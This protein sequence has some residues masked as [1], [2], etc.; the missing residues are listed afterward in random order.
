[1]TPAG[2]SFERLV[3]HGAVGGGVFLRA[4]RWS[5]TIRLITFGCGVAAVAAVAAAV[6]GIAV[7][8][9]VGA[10][11]VVALAT[12]ALSAVR[13]YTVSS[14]EVVTHRLLWNWRLPLAGLRSVQ[15]DPCAMDGSIRLCGVGGCFSWSGLYWNR[16]LGRFWAA[17]TDPG[18][19]VVLRWDRKVVVISPGEPELLVAVVSLERAEDGGG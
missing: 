3:K 6:A 7:F 19:A 16:R 10:A 15:A 12:C 8:R 18:K 14:R 4:A 1:M 13:G 2:V 17:V 9:W 11:M 5:P